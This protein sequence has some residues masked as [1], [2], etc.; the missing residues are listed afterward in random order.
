[1]ENEKFRTAMYDACLQMGLAIVPEDIAAKILAVVYLQG[2]D[3][4]VTA[5]PRLFCE[6]RHIQKKYHIEGGETPDRDFVTLLQGEIKRLETYTDTHDGEWPKD[7]N[8]MMQE[9]YNF[10]P[11]IL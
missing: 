6:I 5:S 3:E 7:I 8:D 4:R 9:R 11:Y 10:K 2:G 1:M